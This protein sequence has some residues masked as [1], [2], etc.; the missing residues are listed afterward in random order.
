ML[1]SAASQRRDKGVTRPESMS[2]R[3]FVRAVNG[4][5]KRGLLA[6]AGDGSGSADWAGHGDGAALTITDAGLNAIGVTPEPRQSRSRHPTQRR[7]LP[8]DQGGDA[9]LRLRSPSRSPQQPRP[10]RRPSAR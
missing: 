7:R 1:L 3:A 6:T 10:D 8:R 9:G 4:L 5:V 2:E